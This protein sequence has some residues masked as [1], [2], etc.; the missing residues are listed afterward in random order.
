MKNIFDQFAK[1]AFAVTLLASTACSPKE[2]E[3]YMEWQSAM[4][5]CL[6]KNGFSGR[7][8]LG[9]TDHQRVLLIDRASLMEETGGGYYPSD[10]KDGFHKMVDGRISD[11]PVSTPITEATRPIVVACFVNADQKY[12][13]GGTSSYTRGLRF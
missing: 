4:T 1:I 3:A 8:V 10:E 7:W 9:I 12:P 11:D 13:E 5:D 2:D 6:A